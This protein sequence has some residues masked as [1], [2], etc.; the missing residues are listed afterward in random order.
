MKTSEKISSLLR[1]KN[2]TWSAELIPPRNGIDFGQVLQQIGVLRDG[3]VDFISVTHGAGGSLRGGTL[4]IA[5]YIKEEFG[6]N[7]VP[8]LTC[9]DMTPE[10]LEN[11]IVDHHYLGFRNILALR[12]D[13]PDGLDAE[14]RPAPGSHAY[15]WQLIHQIARM[16]TG[17]YFARKNFDRS[18][19]EFRE[20]VPTDFCIGAAAYPEEP[21][22]AVS[23]G[24]FALKVRHG[25]SF[26]I[27]QMLFQAEPYFRFLDQ[28]RPRGADV[29]ILPGLRVLTSAAQAARMEKKFG[30]K[31]PASVREKLEKA[32]PG[33]ALETGV[34]AA[35]EL[36]LELIR[37]GAPGIHLFV[38][39]DP[40]SGVR[41]M[42][43]VRAMLSASRPS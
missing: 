7:C 32:P 6:L 29:P 21:D 38:M 41:V 36:A 40:V 31:V 37:G 3:G 34:E 19:G 39:N 25:A 12:G 43:R 15:A 27:T 4:P 23:A 5:T 28:L 22:V 16:N 20:G 11:V 18:D 42:E 14:F 17:R 24:H 8:H 35:A 9:R 2:I 26:G 10:Q 30:V 1:R 13:P 33:Q